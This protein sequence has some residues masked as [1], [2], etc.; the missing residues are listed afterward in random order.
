M[1]LKLKLQ[2]FALRQFVENPDLL[3]IMLIFGISKN[4]G[5]RFF[6]DNTPELKIK[7]FQPLV[8]TVMLEQLLIGLFI[9]LF[10]VYSFVPEKWDSFP[11]DFLAL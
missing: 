6:L 3:P 8:F 2:K 9:K 7:L 5:A 1:F 10:E 11:M 4:I